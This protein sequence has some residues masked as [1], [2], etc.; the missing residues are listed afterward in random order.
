MQSITVPAVIIGLPVSI[1]LIMITFLVGIA[2]G[3]TYGI[4]SYKPL[5]E[6]LKIKKKPKG[7]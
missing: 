6:D 2:S 4:D 3:I 5:E 7:F 1:V